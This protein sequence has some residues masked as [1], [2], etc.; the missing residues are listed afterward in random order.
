MLDWGL[1][2]LPVT[3]STVN[4]NWLQKTGAWGWLDLFV[5]GGTVVLEVAFVYD[6][7]TDLMIFCRKLLMVREI[8]LFLALWAIILVMIFGLVTKVIDFFV[9]LAGQI[10]LVLRHCWICIWTFSLI[11]TDGFVALDRSNVFGR[12]WLSCNEIVEICVWIGLGFKWIMNVVRLKCWSRVAR[13]FWPFPL[14][15]A[16]REGEIVGAIFNMEPIPSACHVFAFPFG[17][18][19]HWSWVWIYCFFMMGTRVTMLASWS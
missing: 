9:H 16:V 10:A 3:A 8:M 18:L 5:C 11:R 6:L 2:F 1:L 4:V 12:G 15:I 14:L 19:F 7:S 17:D 13:L